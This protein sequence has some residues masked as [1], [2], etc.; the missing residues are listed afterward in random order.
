MQR[1]WLGSQWML[2]GSSRSCGAVAGSR[3]IMQSPHW[4][5]VI[6][7][8]GGLPANL[9]IFKISAELLIPP[10]AVNALK[11]LGAFASVND[12]STQPYKIVIRSYRDGAVLRDLY[13]VPYMQNSYNEPYFTAHRTF[14]HNTLLSMTVYLS[15]LD[16]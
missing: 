3:R 13:L 12:Y 4:K 7:Q 9:I 10:N 5:K 14:F 8:G 16:V 15:S 6:K 11:S 2:A 1:H